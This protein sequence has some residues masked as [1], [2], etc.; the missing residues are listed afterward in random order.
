MDSVYRRLLDNQ[1]KWACTIF[2]MF[3][4]ISISIMLHYYGFEGSVYYLLFYCIIALSLVFCGRATLNK[5]E[6]E[7]IILLAYGALI[8]TGEKNISDRK[9]YQLLIE[10]NEMPQSYF[11]RAKK[12]GIENNITRAAS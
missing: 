2:G 11:R 10:K 5:S 12:Y 3:G 7:I 8:A 9:K 6:Y 4:I 1:I